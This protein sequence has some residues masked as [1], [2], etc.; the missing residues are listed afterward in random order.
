M[1]YFIACPANCATGG[2]ELLH[3]L[4]WSLSNRGVENYMLYYN[5]DPAV[6][7]TPD[8][9][10]KYQVKY[11]TS[12]VDD[13]ES[14]LI[15]P[16][17]YTSILSCCIRGVVIIWWLSVDNYIVAYRNCID[18]MNQF[19]LCDSE[20]VVRKNLLHFVQ[21]KYAEEYVK[22]NFLID[23]QDIAYSLTDYINEDIIY[24]GKRYSRQFTRE[25]IVLYNPKKGMQNLRQLIEKCR[26]DIEWIPLVGFTPVQMAMLMCR[27][28]VYIDFGNHPGK[29]RI[30]REAAVCGCCIITNREGSAAYS[31]DVGIPEKYKISD[32]QDYEH[33][34]T[35]LYDL[36][37]HYEQRNSQFEKYITSVLQ[38]KDRFESEVDNMLR[39]VNTKRTERRLY[40]EQNKYGPVSQSMQK[41][42]T[43][44]SELYEKF[45]E[46]YTYGEIDKAIEMLLNVDYLMLTLRET[47]YTVISDALT[48][49][50]SEENI[51]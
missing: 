44:I 30:P 11:V 22:E 38:E 39:I 24:T 51:H 9:F 8:S 16:E 37:D 4:S 31:E 18:Q 33:V 15:C 43:K 34:L 28:K 25:N 26:T 14:V 46:F 13:E 45:R 21:S 29:D 5:V 50:S 42:V 49:K 6:P 35:I 3:Q 36:V 48:N 2:T 19:V 32:M 12:F 27:A 20:S 40:W 41:T 17:V 47:N 23:G 10:L 7:S 1:R